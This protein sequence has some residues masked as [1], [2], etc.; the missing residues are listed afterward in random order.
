MTTFDKI[1]N[2]L[3]ENKTMNDNSK[4]IYI[5]R[6]NTLK[7]LFKNPKELENT[8][9]LLESLKDS[10]LNTK[11]SYIN[12]IIALKRYSNAFNID[13]QDYKNVQYNLINSREEKLSDD[14]QNKPVVSWKQLVEIREKYASIEYAGL[15]HLITSLYTIIAPL[16]DDFGDVEFITDSKKDNNTNNF[17]NLKTNTLILNHYKG[18]ERIK[19]IKRR[20]KEIKFPDELD[21]IIKDSLKFYPR[22]YLITKKKLKSDDDLYN[23]FLLSGLVKEIFGGIS[24]NEI[25]HSFASKDFVGKGLD[26][27][28]LSNDA[29]A[30]QHTLPVHL[31]YFRGLNT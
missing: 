4:K 23:N 29:K 18:S 31:T 26:L 12:T 8:D 13:D 15:E 2:E 28:N 14:I 30:M 22:I 6:I 27:K 25:R 21:K 1:I 3:K 19:S 16:R 7:K 17:Y 10:T 9:A 24:I 5:S 20:K 11:L